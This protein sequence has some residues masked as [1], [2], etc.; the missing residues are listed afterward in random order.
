[1]CAV[2]S[3]GGSLVESSDLLAVAFHLSLAHVLINSV[4]AVEVPGVLF[5]S[6]PTLGAWSCYSCALLGAR[7]LKISRVVIFGSVLFVTMYTSVSSVMGNRLA[8]PCLVCQLVTLAATN[9]F[10]FTSK[11]DLR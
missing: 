4:I 3:C 10:G 1:M 2:L 8:L 9:P 5:S 6:L 11:Y 7:S